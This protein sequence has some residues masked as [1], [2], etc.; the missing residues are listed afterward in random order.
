M[1]D[2]T[3]FPTDLLPEKLACFVHET[4]E[5]LQCDAAMVALPALA[6]CGASIGTSRAIELKKSWHEPPVIWACVIARSGTMKSPAFDAALRPLREAQHDQFEVH[7]AALEAVDGELLRYE[8]ELAAWKKKKTASDQP[9]KPEAP[10]CV[11]H[12]VADATIEA[13]APVL[14]SNARGVLLARDELAAW[15]RGFNQYKSG[16]GADAAAWLELWRAGPLTIDRK[17]GE[18]RRIYIPRAAASVCGTIQP[19]VF[20]T[21]MRGE[22]MECGLAARLLVAQPSCAPKKWTESVPSG[23]ALDGYKSVVRELLEL[24]HHEGKQGPEPFRLPLTPEALKIWREWANAHAIRTHEAATDADAAA[25]AKLEAY[26]ARLALIF[27]LVAD[28]LANIVG[29]GAIARGVELANWFAREAER[30][31]G[32][33]DDDEETRELRELVEWIKRKGGRVT[34]RDLARAL[35]RF[36]TM[37]EA[38]AALAG[39]AEAGLGQYQFSGAGTGRPVRV[40]ALGD[41]DGDDVPGGTGNM[42]EDDADDMPEMTA[43]EAAWLHGLDD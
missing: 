32:R 38:D 28:P 16:R 13:L 14:E 7:R 37:A 36:P 18:R 31:Y 22:N 5:A 20:A 39:L 35:R 43:E 25:L 15:V 11:R 8:A 4:A 33:L 26:A 34:A 3:P 2:Y 42:I 12:I 29:A 6:V 40:F 1:S 9:V 27:E 21:I 10:E 23:A 41:A 19:G 30:I 17:T 24:A